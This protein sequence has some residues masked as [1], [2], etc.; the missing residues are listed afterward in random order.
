MQANQPLW[1]SLYIACL[2]LNIEEVFYFDFSPFLDLEEVL[3]C[4]KG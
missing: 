2:D 4:N 1:F 3:G